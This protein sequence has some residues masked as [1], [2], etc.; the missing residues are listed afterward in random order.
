MILLKQPHVGF[1]RGWNVKTHHISCNPPGSC[2]V[3][4]HRYANIFPTPNRYSTSSENQLAIPQNI[5]EIN[6]ISSAFQSHPRLFLSRN[7]SQLGFSPAPVG[8]LEPPL[9]LPALLPYKTLRISTASKHRQKFVLGCNLWYQLADRTGHLGH[10][11]TLLYIYRG[12]DQYLLIPFLGG[13]S[14]P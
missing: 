10:Y 11:Q 1:C 5:M 8:C 6:G 7:E 14:H 12:M 9:W 4:V 2:Q 13:Y 3:M